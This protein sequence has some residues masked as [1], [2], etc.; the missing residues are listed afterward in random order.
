MLERR[1]IPRSRWAQID[2]EYVAG[3]SGY[4]GPD[5]HAA[6]IRFEIPTRVD[7]R[8]G[9]TPNSEVEL[10]GRPYVIGLKEKPKAESQPTE[11]AK[12]AK[13]RDDS[14]Q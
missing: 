9:R 4:V 12:E 2:V 10:K 14:G 11:A 6:R 5:G 1:R 8:R 13:D 3:L 7:T